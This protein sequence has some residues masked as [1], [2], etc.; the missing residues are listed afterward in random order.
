MTLLA[1]EIFVVSFIVSEKNRKKDGG[2]IGASTL[3]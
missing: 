3:K 2:C 1:Q